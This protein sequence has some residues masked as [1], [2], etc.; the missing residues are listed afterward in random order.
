MQAAA[1]E[2]EGGGA[3]GVAA[4]MRRGAQPTGEVPAPQCRAASRGII[5]KP[6]LVYPLPGRPTKQGTTCLV[7]MIITGGPATSRGRRVANTGI[8]SDLKSAC[9]G[10]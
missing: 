8:N 10:L 7:I 1:G 2:A 4:V 5:I 3:S 9:L 6:G